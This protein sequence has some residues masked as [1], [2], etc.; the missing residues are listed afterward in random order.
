MFFSKIKLPGLACFANAN[1]VASGPIY[2]FWRG[3]KVRSWRHALETYQFR[4]CGHLR[5]GTE[6]INEPQS[7]WVVICQLGKLTGLQSAVRIQVTFLG[8]FRNPKQ[9]KAV[10]PPLNFSQ[11]LPAP[12]RG[13]SPPRTPPPRRRRRRWSSA[14][15]PAA[16]AA[17]PS[18]SRSNSAARCPPRPE[19]GCAWGL[20]R[21][22]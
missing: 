19:A 18:R 16:T 7:A 5:I 2:R 22:L 4:R 3:M 14:R 12:P 8:L 17:G 10:L 21:R 15:P 6:S 11:L 1:P 9:P 20:P 13:F